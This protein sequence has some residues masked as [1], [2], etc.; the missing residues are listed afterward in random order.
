MEALTAHIA[1]DFGQ[2]AGYNAARGSYQAPVQ[3]RSVL[4]CGLVAKVRARHYPHH[5]ANR[6]RRRH[7]R[8]N[9]RG[10]SSAQGKRVDHEL[11]SAVV[12]HPVRRQHPMTSCLLAYWESKGHRLVACQVPVRVRDFFMCMT[13]ADVLTTDSAGRL[14]LWEVKTGAPVGFHRRQ[15]TLQHVRGAEVPCNG[16]ALWQLQLH[17]TRRALEAAGVAVANARVIQ[18]HGQRKKGAGLEVVV[19]EPPEWVHRVQHQHVQ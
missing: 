3:G 2:R 7:S 14:W 6:S 10:S 18:V 1:S 4:L 12:G 8:V 16:Q 19:H 9:V 5:Q 11:Q 13:E 15:G 17:Y